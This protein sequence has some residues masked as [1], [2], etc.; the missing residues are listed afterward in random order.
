MTHTLEP[1]IAS[2][3]SFGQ[4]EMIV[5][6]EDREA[7]GVI[8]I[9]EMDVHFDG[10]CGVEQQ[11]N[12]RRIVACVNALAGYPTEFLENLSMLGETI[13]DRVKAL[14]QEADEANKQRD[15]L[16][17]AAR[18]A[19]SVFARQK[20]RDD[21]PDPEAVALRMLRAAIARAEGSV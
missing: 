5:T 9:C 3:G 14:K 16:L 6:T 20:W 1:W 11:A 21:S 10:P 7:R 13:T 12:A 17:A 2:Q 8:P 18:A 4:M 19:E 15:D